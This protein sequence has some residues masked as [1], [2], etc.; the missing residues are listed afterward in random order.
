MHIKASLHVGDDIIT[1]VLI[2]RRVTCIPEG[3]RDVIRK[4]MKGCSF[5]DVLLEAELVMSGIMCADMHGKNYSR[6][7]AC[8]WNVFCL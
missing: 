1:S 2:V 4:K 8:H 7:M 6:A 5:S 3:E